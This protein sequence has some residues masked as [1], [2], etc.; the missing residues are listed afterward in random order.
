MNAR[1]RYHLLSLF[2]LLD[3]LTC[4]AGFGLISWLYIATRA[5]GSPEAAWSGEWVLALSVS[6]AT[7]WLATPF[8][9]SGGADAMRTWIEQF[10]TALG[11]ILIVQSGLAYFF[12]ISPIPWWVILAGTVLTIILMALLRAWLYPRLSD[13]TRQAGAKG[14]RSWPVFRVPA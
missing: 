8:W 13:P 12:L 10:F 2:A 5:P 9:E 14:S 4:A 11:F 7:F 1:A 6:A 3:L